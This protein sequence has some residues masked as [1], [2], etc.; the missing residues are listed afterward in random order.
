MFL[1]D[2][3][4][5][6]IVVVIYLYRSN[7]EPNMHTYWPLAYLPDDKMNLCTMLPL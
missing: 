5:I 4:I 2:K 7:L 6:A 3:L 1:Y